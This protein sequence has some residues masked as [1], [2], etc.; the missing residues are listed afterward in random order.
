MTGFIKIFIC[1]LGVEK[2]DR[3]IYPILDWEDHPAIAFGFLSAGL[4]FTPVIH[5]IWVGLARWQCLLFNIVQAMHLFSFVFRLRRIIYVKLLPKEFSVPSIP[6]KVVWELWQGDTKST[7]IFP[8]K[9]NQNSIVVFNTWSAW[10]WI[11]S[12]KLGSSL[13]RMKPQFRLR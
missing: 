13:S 2:C 12:T 1:F 6:N 8:A 11:Q 10:S 3:Y 7:V 4:L 5:S 9:I